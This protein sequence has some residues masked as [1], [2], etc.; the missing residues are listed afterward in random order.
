MMTSQQTHGHDF[1]GL[2]FGG[3]P[4]RVH[5]WN[6]FVT[7]TENLLAL[8]P[9]TLATVIN[10][11]RGWTQTMP[12]PAAVS[13]LAPDAIPGV[14][15]IFA[16]HFVGPVNSSTFLWR[17][18]GDDRPPTLDELAAEAGIV[19]DGDNLPAGVVMNPGS[20]IQL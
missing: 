17:F 12:R 15:G 14:C 10:S 8:Y 7:Q 4:V 13:L 9:N 5:T 3:R 18:V 11:V 1:G 19:V 2:L 6:E 20:L 16:V